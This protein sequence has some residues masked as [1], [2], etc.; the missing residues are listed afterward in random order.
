MS[1]LGTDNLRTE[2]P[3]I[4]VES[5][6]ANCIKNACYNLRLG[7]EAYITNAANKKKEILDDKNPQVV[8][9]PGQFLY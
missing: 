1:F 3:S 6:E 2:L 9:E 5:F 7:N 8:I 4:I